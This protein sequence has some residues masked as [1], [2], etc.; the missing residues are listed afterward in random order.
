MRATA[1]VRLEAQNIRPSVL[2]VAIM[3]YL[4]EH[5]DHPTADEI[6]RAL[7]PSIPSLSKTSVYNTLKLFSEHHVIDTLAITPENI[8]YDGTLDPH[9]HF[10]CERCGKI[11]DISLSRSMHAELI[12][13]G[14]EGAEPIQASVCLR[15][16]CAEC[17]TRPQAGISSCKSESPTI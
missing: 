13:L 12:R 3:Q 10:Q 4:L 14:P 2:R 5:R 17:R 15:G 11:C 8:C 9:A 6:W 16:I 1:T 7:Q